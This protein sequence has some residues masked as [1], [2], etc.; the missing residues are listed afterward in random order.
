MLFRSF[1]TSD[2]SA[3]AS[4][5]LAAVAVVPPPSTSDDLDI[6]R[7][8]ETVMTIQLMVS[9]SW[10]CLMSFDLWEQ[11]WRVL[12]NCL[13]HLL[14]MMSSDCPLVICHKKGEYI[15]RGDFV[16]FRLYLGA[17]FCIYIFWLMMYFVL[18]ELSMIG[19]D[20]VMYLY[21][22]LVSHCATL[23]IDF[24]L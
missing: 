7:M 23:I 2:T 8:L 19:G 18:F 4:V 13:R 14:L 11:I 24:Y 3:K 6:R 20:T 1:S 10:T 22:F 5:D 12:D 21:L 9:F 15:C 16:V 17:S